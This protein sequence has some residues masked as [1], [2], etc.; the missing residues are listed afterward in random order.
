ME[1]ASIGAVILVYQEVNGKVRDA[2]ISLHVTTEGTTLVKHAEE[3]RG[4]LTEQVFVRKVIELHDNHKDAPI[5]A[6]PIQELIEKAA[7]GFLRVIICYVSSLQINT[8]NFNH[9]PGWSRKWGEEHFGN[10]KVHKYG[11][12]TMGKSWD[13]VLDEEIYC[14]WYQ[15][16]C[17]SVRKAECEANLRK[18]EEEME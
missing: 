14:E 17:K 12:S 11:K 8:N 15:N 16:Y 6:L 5:A 13:I 7:D 18:F 1:E 10:G 9:V 3:R 4:W 2:V